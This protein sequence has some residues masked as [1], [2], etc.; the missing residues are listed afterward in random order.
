MLIDII[1]S[2][3]YAIYASFGQIFFLPNQFNLE[4]KKILLIQNLNYILFFESLIKYGVHI[5]IIFFLF[6]RTFKDIKKYKKSFLYFIP[7]LLSGYFLNKFTITFLKPRF[8]AY[9]CVLVLIILFFIFVERFSKKNFPKTINHISKLDLFLICLSQI[10]S[11]K[12]HLT[13]FAP[14][15]F[16]LT[17]LGY[18]KEESAFFGLILSVPTLYLINDFRLIRSNM[19]IISGVNYFYLILGFITS[20]TFAYFIF[21]KIRGHLFNKNNKLYRFYR[22]FLIAKV[23]L[24][25]FKIF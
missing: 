8:L 14:L 15:F 12:I 6:K 2:F 9:I 23:L 4:V 11:Y 25:R 17:A 13:T 24:I 19:H 18:K 1:K 10:I 3:L 20:F 7:I 22:L 5:A 21:L 16:T